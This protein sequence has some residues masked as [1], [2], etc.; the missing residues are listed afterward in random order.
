MGMVPFSLSTPTGWD[1]TEQ[2]SRLQWRHT[3][4]HQTLSLCT[5]QLLIYWGKSDSES[6]QSTSPSDQHRHHPP[7]TKNNSFFFFFFLLFLFWNQAHSSLLFVCMFVFFSFSPLCLSLFWIWL[8]YSF[9]PLLFFFSSVFF[10][11]HSFSTESALYLSDSLFIWGF[12]GCCCSLFLFSFLG[13]SL[14]PHFFSRVNSTNKSN[15][16]G[17]RS[18]HSPLQ[19]KRFAENWSVGMSSQNATA[20]CMQHTPETLPGVPDPGQC[21]I[22]F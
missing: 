10:Y 19:A 7:G 20:E 9:F 6:M 13:I 22:P 14:L 12:F 8:F 18:K 11:P 3:C 1:F 4:L 15:T 5:C 21:T 2:H 17:E 16:P